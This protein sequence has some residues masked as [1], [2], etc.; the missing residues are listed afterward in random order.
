MTTS[1]R[2]GHVNVIYTRLDDV[3]ESGTNERYQY[4]IEG[5]YKYQYFLAYHENKLKNLT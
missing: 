5:R 2:L 3:V 1:A 4:I